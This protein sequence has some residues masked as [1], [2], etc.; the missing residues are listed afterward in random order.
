ME[1][2][3]ENP[4]R[5]SQQGYLPAWSPD[6]K[7]IV[8]ADNDFT[9]PS[10]RRGATSRLHILDLATG[11]E[12]QLATEDAIQPN[13]SPHGHR[14]A[15]WGLSADA[16][17]ERDIFTVDAA[18]GAVVQV[19]RDPAL[20]WNPVWSP[21]GDYLYFLSDRGGA[22]NL[23]RVR[24]DERN[25]K[26]RG[27]PEPVTTPAEAMAYLSFSADGRT[28]AYAEV[29]Q[30]NNLFSVG[31]DAARQAV[32]GEPVLVGSG[33]HNVTVF[34]FSPDDSRLVYDAVGDVQEDLWVMNSDGSGR[35]R[36]TDDPFRD[37]S[38]A[39]SPKG[40]EIVFMS[41]RAGGLDEWT[42]RPDG[43]GLRRLTATPEHMQRPV[44]TA[45]G[46]Q[47]LASRVPGPASMVDPHPASPA[48]ALTP[49]PGLAKFSGAIFS[50]F[51]EHGALLTAEWVGEK[52]WELI[53]YD[54]AKGVASRSGVLGRRPAYMA[55]D[56]QVIFGRGSKCLLYSLDTHREKELFSVGTNTIYEIHPTHDGKR[57]FFTQTIRDADLWL[58]RMSR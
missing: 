42:I 52:G 51:P 6:G 32:T 48:T 56:R 20:D 57:I 4:T 54:L 43:S 25:G 21:A 14:I 15:F 36:L 53:F 40:D 13:W 27:K 29:R 46:K 41:D 16:G 12:R 11:R 55:G 9:V 17:V 30:R 10:S 1:A 28:F 47:V 5:I 44:W 50:P 7:S 34:S 18:S 49:L 58:G 2:T 8:Y 23:W 19:T 33:A 35:R 26:T 3:G 22:M 39:W 24:I 31:Y 45:D 38:P 37:R